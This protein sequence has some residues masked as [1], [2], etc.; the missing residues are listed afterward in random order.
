MLTLKLS[1]IVLIGM[2]GAGKTTMGKKIAAATGRE[3][4][5]MDEVISQRENLSVQDIFHKRGEEYFR[6]KETEVSK[7]FG[8]KQSLVIATGGGCVLREENMRALSQNAIVVFIDRPIGDLDAEGRPLS[9]GVAALAKMYEERRPLYEK[10]GDCIHTNS[11][12]KS[13]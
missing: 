1:N 2:P 9:R 3:F 6:N 10:Y 12:V 8:R 13:Q 5:D 4:V 11:K 7:E